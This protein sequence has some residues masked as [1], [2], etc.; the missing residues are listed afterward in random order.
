MSALLSDP[1]S[2]TFSDVAAYFWEAEWDILGERQKELY[3]KVIKEIHGDLMSRGYSILNPDVIFK[4]KKEDEKYCTQP[5]EREGK[6]TMRDPSESLPI[7]TSVFSLSVKQEEDLPSTEPPVTGSSSIKP[8]LF[9]RFKQ[10]GIKSEPQECEEGGDL[11]IPGAVEILKMEEPHVSNQLEGE[12]EDTDTKS[13]DGFRKN[14]EWQRMYSGEQREDWKQRDPSRD[15]L[16]PSADCEAGIR[17]TPSRVGDKAQ[18]GERLNA[19]TERERNSNHCSNLV[20]SQRL[21]EGERTFK[22]ADT[23]ENFTINPLS[24]EH[25]EK[26]ECENKFTE[27]SSHISIPQYQREK[28][29]TCTEGGK[30]YTNKSN[31]TVH[32]KMHRQDQPI[33]CPSCKK[34]F[35]CKAQLTIHQKFHKEQKPFKCSE[36]E[37]SFRQ[38]YNLIQHEGIH[39]GEKP[40][41]CT[42]CDKYFRCKR[43]MRLHEMIHMVEKPFKCSA[44]DKSFS[45]KSVLRNHEMIHT[46]E[47]PFVCS[48]C[49]KCF[50]RKGHLLQHEMI[51]TQKKPFK[52]FECDKSFSQ[53][54]VLRRHKKIH[55]G[56]KPFKCSECDRSFIQKSDLRNHGK[57]HSGEKPFKCSECDKSFSQKCVLKRHE[58][59]HS[60]E[61]PFKCSECDK[62]FTRKGHLQQHEM[63]HMG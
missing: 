21:Y 15:I 36:C 58:R 28:K 49:D 45:Q 18:N 22:S 31:L 13:D 17:V 63:A 24:F 39:S 57:I 56:E 11:A 38:K 35:T 2:V 3:K 47:K 14:S 44:C 19:C 8:D 23:W 42:E 33:K 62:C 59:T 1:A 27:K 26:I 55:T 53:K 40:F 5:C 6:E 12:E 7:V 16:D 61:K 60:G 46:R 43:N 48:K 20:Q 4:I 32:K 54:C 52:C 29:L 50:S 34:C 10:E 37:K 41:K 25:Q 51:H 30:A 9:I